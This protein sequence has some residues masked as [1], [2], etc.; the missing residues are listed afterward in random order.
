MTKPRDTKRN[1]DLVSS[2]NDDEDDGP[3]L[4]SD[5]E[6]NGIRAT[7]NMDK[8]KPATSY[9]TSKTQTRRNSGRI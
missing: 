3:S 4:L 9:T 6:P 7:S 5:D 2:H 8:R 1:V